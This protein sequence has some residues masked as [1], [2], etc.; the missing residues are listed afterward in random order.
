MAKSVKYPSVSMVIQGPVNDQSKLDFMDAIPYYRQLFPHI[1]V[2][3]YTEHLRGNAKFVNFCIDN[4][5][6]LVHRTIEIGNVRNDSRAFYQ[7]YTTFNGLRAVITPHAIKHR[8][9]ERYSNLELLIDKFLLDTAKWVS[10]S[11]VFPPK[12]YRLYHAADHV[13]VSNTASLIK[14]FDLTLTNLVQGHMETNWPG[15]TNG[16]P[17]ITFTKNFLRVNGE[18]PSEQNHDDLMRKY[19]DLVNNSQMW[20]FVAR[21]NGSGTVYRSLDD[22]GPN[23]LQYQS[24]DDILSKPYLEDGEHNPQDAVFRT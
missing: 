17:E 9:D 18:D 4:E 6:D 15:D 7:A 11:T 13:F 2:S 5:L 19:F 23:R 12:V 21:E 20:P 1:I 24:I 3:S 16:A 10:G 14:T 8:T 22:L